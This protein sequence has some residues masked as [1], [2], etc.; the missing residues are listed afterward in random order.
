MKN[1]IIH[2]ELI[3]FLLNNIKIKNIILIFSITHYCN[4]YSEQMLKKSLI[5]IKNES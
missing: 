3:D 4:Q 5:F 2:L 1:A